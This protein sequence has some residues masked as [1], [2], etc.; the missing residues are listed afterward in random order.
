[1]QEGKSK[2][3]CFSEEENDFENEGDPVLRDV[4]VFVN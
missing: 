4:W 3:K 1:M 2:S